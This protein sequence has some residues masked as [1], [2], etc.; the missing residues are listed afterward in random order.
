MSAR[1]EFERWWDDR[2]IPVVKSLS[3]ETAA[4]LAF[5]AAYQAGLEAAAKA[6]RANQMKTND[7][8]E[9]NAHDLD[10]REILKLKDEE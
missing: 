9:V 8:F 7:R 3:A 10:E 5:D 1:E 6:C 2:E 4:A